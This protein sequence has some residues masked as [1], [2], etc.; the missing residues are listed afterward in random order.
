[1]GDGVCRAVCCQ[2]ASKGVLTNGIQCD[3]RRGHTHH[4]LLLFPFF[5]F[6]QLNLSAPTS[7]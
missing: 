2:Q 3:L 6:A 1:M 5:L 4:H 7:R